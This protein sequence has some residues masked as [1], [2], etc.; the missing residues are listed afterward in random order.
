[1]EDLFDTLQLLSWILLIVFLVVMIA[2]EWY[3]FVKKCTKVKDLDDIVRGNNLD[4]EVLKTK[5][6]GIE[7]GNID[8]TKAQIR[9][10]FVRTKYLG[11]LVHKDL[12]EDFKKEVI[13]FDNMKN[14][15]LNYKNIEK[16]EQYRETLNKY[17][18]MQIVIDTYPNKKEVK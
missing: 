12:I 2:T 3:L 5:M 11:K 10:Y 9:D 1:M 4:I 14:D 8:A 13:D 16:F 7:N 17:E 18:L 6:R 15:L